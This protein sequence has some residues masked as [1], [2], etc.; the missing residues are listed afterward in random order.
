MVTVCLQRRLF[1]TAEKLADYIWQLSESDSTVGI[2]SDDNQL[3]L[4]SA[5]CPYINVPH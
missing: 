1:L 5:V 3:M 4:K 2:I